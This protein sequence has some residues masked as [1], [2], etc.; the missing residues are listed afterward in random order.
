MRLIELVK[1]IDIV[2]Y[3]DMDMGLNLYLQ[4]EIKCKNEFLQ[5]IYDISYN[6]GQQYK[7]KTENTSE[8]K[9]I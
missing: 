4:D 3:P 2:S 7:I 1:G 9:I 5:H 6:L 8:N